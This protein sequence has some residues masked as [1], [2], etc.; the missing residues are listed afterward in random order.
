M[1]EPVVPPR[2][3]A[4][5]AAVAAPK[6][7][8]DAVAAEGEA[9]APPRPPPAVAAGAGAGASGGGRRVFSVELRPG[10]T[11]IVSW[12]KMLK[13]ADLGAALPPP[14][15][16]AAAQPAVAP[17]PGPSGATHPTENDC[18]QSNRFNSVIEKIERLY[19]GKNSSDEEDLDDAPDDD[20]YDTE[21]SFIDD[22]ELDEYF[23]VDNFA[24]KHN[25]YFVNKGKLEQID[26]DSVQTVEP[27]KRRRKD[28]SSSYIENNKEFSPGSSS[29]MGT[30]LRDSKRS[31]LQT[32]KSTSNGHKSGANGTFE[33]P[34]S[35]YRDKD[36]PGHLGLQ[37]KITSNGANQDLSKNMH[38]KEKYNA[39]QFSGLHASSNIYS[40]ETMHL[41]TKIHTEG[42]GTKTKGTRLERAIRDLQNIVTEYKPQI[43]DVHEAEANCQV[44]VKRRLPQEVKQK[45]AKV[46]RLSANQ[47]KIPEHELINRLM[48]IVGHLVHRR[49]LKRNMKEMVQSG[50][51]A[52]QEKAG[53]LQQ[54]KMEIYEM[55]KARLATKPK[56][57]EHKVESIDGFQDP[58]THDDRMALRGKSVMDAVLEDR[59]CDLY[60]LYVE[61]MDED[62]GPQSRKLYLELANLWP[63]G[64]MDKV[65]IRDAISRSKE[66]RNLLYRQRKVRNDQRMKRRRLAAAAK[67]RDSDPAA[68]QSAQ[69]LQNMTSTHTMYPVVNNGNSQSSRSVDKVNEMSVGA[70]SDGNRSSTSM[71]KRKIDSEDRQVNP[72]KATAELHHHGIEIQKPA[73]RADEATKVSNLPQTLLAIPSSDSRP[74]SS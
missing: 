24:T 35:A 25:G 67:L 10:E 12:R 17:L 13:E 63:H 66:R 30:P 38:H 31:T 8:G 36:A 18:A 60:D 11:T 1:G 34:Y 47:G 61:G 28:S 64:D 72:P 2:A 26:F 49:T 41:A 32:G 53:K 4:A 3:P 68:P 5:H 52:K 71:K 40:T 65:G 69:S 7:P 22:D 51:C 45:L 21:D 29:Y 70:G 16:A 27:K 56:G 6:P 54:V 73:K 14:P 9:R 39:G 23:E 50:L 42:S 43:L 46:A 37:Q 55:V 62:K 59:I 44:A 48:G 74:S 33:Y 20:Q 58:V 15:P 19:M 57:A